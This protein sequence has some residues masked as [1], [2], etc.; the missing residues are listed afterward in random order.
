MLKLFDCKTPMGSFY[1]Y[2]EDKAEAMR[3]FRHRLTLMQVKIVEI[4]KKIWIASYRAISSVMPG[5]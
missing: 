5:R 1:I 4:K 3:I 2:C